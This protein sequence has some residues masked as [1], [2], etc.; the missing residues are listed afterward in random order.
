MK[1]Q[2][3]QTSLQKSDSGPSYSELKKLY[4][5]LQKE[6]ERVGL[7]FQNQQ[8]QVEELAEEPEQRK[9]DA[10]EANNDL[11]ELAD[12]VQTKDE[13]IKVL[14]N[15]LADAKRTISALKSEIQELRSSRPSSEQE[16]NHDQQQQRPPGSNR[17]SSHSL[18][19]IHQHYEKV[20][21]AIQD[22]NCSM[23]NAFCLTSFP[24]SM[25][26]DFV[27]IAE[28]MIIHFIAW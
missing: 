5:N 28:V 21:Q 26:C 15:R 3:E 1:K 13:A 6:H 10:E 20:L 7:A 24:R 19:S 23:A 27:A 22:H 9:K 16:Q 11:Q 18:H 12:L 4:K 2:P 14:Q 8:D 17:V 25:L